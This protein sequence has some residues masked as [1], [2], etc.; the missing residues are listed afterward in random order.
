MNMKRVKTFWIAWLLTMICVSVSY[1]ANVG[2]SISPVGSVLKYKII[3][4]N[5]VA[6]AEVIGI[7]PNPTYIP[8][9]ISSGGIVY[10]VK[11][12]GENAFKDCLSLINISIVS[13]LVDS[14]GKNAFAGCSSLETVTATSQLKIFDESAFSGCSSLTT[15][16]LQNATR[17]GAY[18]FNNC[19][20]LEEVAIPSSVHIIG[21][22]AFNGCSSLAKIS[23]SWPNPQS[24]PDIIGIDIFGDVIKSN[25]KLL[26]PAVSASIYAAG[27]TA[28]APWNGFKIPYLT[29][30]PYA[31]QTTFPLTLAA[32]G[33]GTASFYIDSNVEWSIANNSTAWLTVNSATIGSGSSIIPVSASEYTTS[34]IDR[35]ATLTVSDGDGL[36]QT[37]A[38]TQRGKPISTETITLGSAESYYDIPVATGVAW[39]AQL[40][41]TSTW[42]TIQFANTSGVATGIGGHIRLYYDG[43]GVNGRSIGLN[44]IVGGQTYS[45][46]IFQEGL[47]LNV[48]PTT[49]P[50]FEAEGG[51]EELDLVSGYNWTATSSQS[52]LHV[53]PTS[54]SLGSRT[55]TVKADANNTLTTANK[56]EAK[57]TVRTTNASPNVT[58]EITVTQKEPGAVLIYSPSTFSV[59]PP[60]LSQQTIQITSNVSWTVEIPTEDVGWLSVSR[61]SGSGNGS[62]VLIVAANPNKVSR[63]GKIVI[64]ENGGSD[65][66]VTI[67]QSAAGS[68]LIPDSVALSPKSLLLVKGE[69]KELTATIY[70]S[71]AQNKSIIWATDNANI[72]TVIDG[73]VIGMAVGTTVVRVFTVEGSK[74]AACAVEVGTQANEP[75]A[76]GSY[77]SVDDGKL[78]V[79]TP[80]AEQISIYTVGGTLLRKVQKAAGEATF[81]LNG[82][83]KGILIIRGDSGWTR[84]AVF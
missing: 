14:I 64:K 5:A 56:R 40:V 71:T 33:V 63:S 50:I 45:I 68:G 4:T 27:N 26:F 83:P 79:S 1:A 43:N 57:I 60:T 58:R 46:N 48:A 78:T 6:V 77:V 7:P 81:D 54:G 59:F 34:T 30:T 70:P 82:L 51:E 22:Y 17:I 65:R 24:W 13:S 84:K 76:D 15:V 37:V 55:L 61:T 2:D 19:S 36:V 42:I 53:T 80:A 38:V 21:L 66:N 12:I 44:V 32:S 23:V 41:Y 25:V 35:S 16:P 8:A 3:S 62:F 67:S 75:E 29:V 39:S 72:A 11:A 18:A 74:T 10:N 49:L 69:S 31:P 9:T 20:S 28:I 47:V 52:W 73:R